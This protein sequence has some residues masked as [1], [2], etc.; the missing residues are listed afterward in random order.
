MPKRKLSAMLY[1]FDNMKVMIGG[2]GGACYVNKRVNLMGIQAICG[3]IWLK[4]KIRITL[5]L[6]IKDK[7]LPPRKKNQH[8]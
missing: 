6:I 3:L 7:C 8:F 5:R 2:Y 1:Y 4:A